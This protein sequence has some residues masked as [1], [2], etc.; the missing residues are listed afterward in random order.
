MMTRTVI[1]A[2]DPD[3]C[4]KCSLGCKQCNQFV[5]CLQKNST[6]LAILPIPTEADIAL[7][8]CGRGPAYTLL[9]D[10]WKRAC[11]L[12]SHSG[13]L[14]ITFA[15]QCGVRGM[16]FSDVTEDTLWQCRSNVE[17][18]LN[19]T[20]PTRVILVGEA[21]K[22]TQLRKRYP[23]A[24]RVMDLQYIVDRGGL[25]AP[26]CR[27]LVVALKNVIVDVYTAPKAPRVTS[28]DLR[29]FSAEDVK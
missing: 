5:G 13:V 6:A 2:Q 17:H 20:R 18:V 19:V 9:N 29:R 8:T 12:C 27:T 14:S 4:R 23:T 22:S 7:R 15:V 25:E 10:A 24:T 26:E 21:G 16:L 3:R 28:G 1:S 11:H